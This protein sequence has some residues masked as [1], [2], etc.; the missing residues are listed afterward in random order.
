LNLTAL[1]KAGLRF[2]KNILLV[3]QQRNIVLYLKE[4]KH[5]Q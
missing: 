1:F 2:F 5:T 4:V 3:S